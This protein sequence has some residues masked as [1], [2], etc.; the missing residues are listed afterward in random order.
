VELR[1]IAFIF[2]LLLGIIAFFLVPILVG[3]KETLSFVAQVGIVGAIVLVCNG[4]FQIIIPSAGWA[5]ILRQNGH[6]VPFF[7]LCKANLM[8][9]WLN[10][11]TP[12]FY[13]G[14]EPL[15]AFYVS[16]RH[17]V[18]MRDVVAS[19]IVNKFQEFGGVLIVLIVGFGFISFTAAITLPGKV[20]LGFFILFFLCLFLGAFFSFT[21][22]FKPVVKV[23]NFLIRLRIFGIFTRQLFRLRKKAEEME[24]IVRES[25]VKKWK[26]YFIA[27]M[28]TTLSAVSLFIRPWLFYYFLMGPGFHLSF[29]NLCVIY[30]LS[31]IIFTFQIIPGNLGIF[32]G[33]SVGIF[34][35]IG[36]HKQHATAFALLARVVDVSLIV[37][38]IW[39]LVSLGLM[40]VA[41][42]REKLKVHIEQK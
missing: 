26:T 38:G 7:T 24:D 28:L 2:S 14:G 3:V 12:S 8:G 11:I 21:G 40:S 29:E 23:L 5:I 9:F 10:F 33:T 22:N 35:L 19:I 42:E 18:H 37:C 39:L 32:E 36:L 31:Q 6:P 1:R 16:K 41:R 17:D 25:I 13:L 27:Q 20:F 30:S 15:K 34:T 4:F